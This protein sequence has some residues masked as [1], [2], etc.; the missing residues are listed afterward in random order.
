MMQHFTPKK[1]IGTLFLGTALAGLAACDQQP[2]PMADV[3]NT[4]AIETAPASAPSPVEAASTNPTETGVETAPV[5]SVPAT[6]RRPAGP[7]AAQP[8]RTPT[9]APTSMDVAEPAD[10]H[11]GHNM[12]SM[13]DHD[14]EGM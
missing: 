7:D 5:A 12:E 9:P 13:S 8:P 11:A 2:E 1:M 14:M 10:P 3:G 6:E 4:A